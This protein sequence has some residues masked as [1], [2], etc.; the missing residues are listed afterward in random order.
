MRPGVLLLCVGLGGVDRRRSEEIPRWCRQQVVPPPTVGV[1]S[2]GYNLDSSVIMPGNVFQ[3]EI[4]KPGVGCNPGSCFPTDS[5]CR[6]PASRQTLAAA[7]SKT[8][9][10]AHAARWPPNGSRMRRRR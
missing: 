3:V 9:A 5:S 7:R 10:W 8:P 6:A 1:H 2:F 4:A